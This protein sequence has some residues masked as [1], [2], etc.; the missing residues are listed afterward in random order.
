MTTTLKPPI[1]ANLRELK[2]SRGCTVRDIA[3]ALEV[4]ERSVQMWLA[5]DGSE[6]SWPN[7]CKLAQFF[8]V[9]PAHFYETAEERSDAY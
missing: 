6:P 5:D 1:A 7:V 2:Q 8:Q 9:R 4:G 3:V